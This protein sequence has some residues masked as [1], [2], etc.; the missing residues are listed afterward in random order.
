M[1]RSEGWVYRDA[2][3][4]LLEVEVVP[5]DADVG[6]EKQRAVLNMRSPSPEP[7]MSMTEIRPPEVERSQEAM[8]TAALGWRT[9]TIAVDG[10]PALFET[11]DLGNDFWVAVAPLADCVL[12]LRSHGVGRLHV[13][14]VRATKDP[15]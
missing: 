10:V 1:G 15:E 11:W 2:L 7:L 13:A 9:G 12:I 8:R 3:G 14:L 6:E 4:R 5:L